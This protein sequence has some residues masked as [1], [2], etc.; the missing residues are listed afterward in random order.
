MAVVRAFREA[1][2]GLWR[3]GM[4]GL[5][6]I[7]TTAASLTVLGVFAQMV[8]SGYTLADSLR[9]KVEVEVYLKEGVSRSKALA[10]VRA[11]EAAPGVAEAR[12]IDKA[13][14]AE[15]FQQM[16]GSGLLEAVSRNPLPT[17]IRVRLGGGRDLTDRAR[18]FAESVA[19]RTEVETVDAGGTWLDTLDQALITVTWVG[20]LLGGVLCLACALA[21]S[22]TAKLMVL[23][24]R[25]AIEIMRLVGASGGF[26]RLTFLL[27]GAVQGFAG[28]GLAVLALWISAAGWTA[29]MPDAQQMPFL[30]PALGLIG[31][32]TVLGIV[33]SWVSL[34][35]VLRAVGRG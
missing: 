17:S 15:E 29:W 33:G 30:Y 31:L 9:K 1:F 16:F 3:T 11:F 7:V 12:Y 22:N 23:A 35:R 4:V 18:A 14:A 28:G 19:R 27:G 5:V 32:G 24:Q 26:I 13:A 10:L 34:N 2:R 8:T 21:V 20:V 6:S 25:E